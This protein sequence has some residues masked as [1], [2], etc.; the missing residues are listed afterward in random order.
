M[1][2]LQSLD[3]GI[4]ASEKEAKRRHSLLDDDISSNERDAKRRHVELS[5]DVHQIDTGMHEW[6][7]AQEHKEHSKS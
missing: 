3:S 1:T 2:R 7:S 5:Q 6:R 4:L